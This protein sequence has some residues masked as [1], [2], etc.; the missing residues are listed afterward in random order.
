[1]RFFVRTPTGETFFLETTNTDTWLDVKKMIAEREGISID[2]QRLIFAGQPLADQRLVNEHRGFREN[3]EINL[4]QSLENSP[5]GMVAV[6]DEYRQVADT[7]EPVIEAS[8]P[9]LA[10]SGT[11]IMAFNVS[12]TFDVMVGGS[13]AADLLHSAQEQGIAIVLVTGNGTSDEVVDRTLKF[14]DD[15][16]I[17]IHPEYYSGSTPDDTGI[18][19]PGLEQILADFNISK[20]ELVFFDDS[21]SNIA[22]AQAAGFQTIHVTGAEALQEGILNALFMDMED[23]LAI[24]AKGLPPVAVTSPAVTSFQEYGSASTSAGPSISLGDGGIEE[25]LEANRAYWSDIQAR[26]TLFNDSDLWQAMGSSSHIG[27]E[28]S[29]RTW[30]SASQ[31][32]SHGMFAGSGAAQSAPVIPRAYYSYDD[33]TEDQRAYVSELAEE[34]SI[35]YG[36]TFSSREFWEMNG[37]VEKE[38]IFQNFVAARESGSF[39]S[40]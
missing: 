15:Y 32:P 17:T 13:V 6:Q 7:V 31:L 35:A 10:S 22:E 11:K 30:V 5:E 27:Q 19:I 26:E 40:R 3:G 25:D 21:A 12:E 24:I 33:L 8:A 28:D 14:F 9:P 39:N 4:L 1:M 34:A 16:G 2:S 20:S 38:E 29:Q 36:H 23:G 18:K 37:P